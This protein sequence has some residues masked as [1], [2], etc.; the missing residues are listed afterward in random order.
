MPLER[1]GVASD[2]ALVPNDSND[3]PGCLANF[4]ITNY[5]I[6]N[7]GWHKKISTA[8]N[9]ARRLAIKWLCEKVRFAKYDWTWLLY[10]FKLLKLKPRLAPL[11]GREYILSQLN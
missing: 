5:I 4:V 11:A 10:T 2:F 1:N 9:S 3:S 8:K 6:A 7:C